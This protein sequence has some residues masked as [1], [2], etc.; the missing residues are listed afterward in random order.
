MGLNLP[1]AVLPAGTAN[2]FATLLG[3]PTDIEEAC[4]AILAG[5]IH[6]MDLGRA[7]GRYFANVF[8]CGLFTDVSQK[9]PTAWK[10]NLGKIAYYI[11]GIGDLPRFRK[12]E[13]LHH[14]RRRRLPRQ[15]HHLLRL[16]R[17]HGRH[18]AARLSLRGGRR[19]ARHFG[20]QRRYAA[21]HPAHGHPV[22]AP[23]ASPPALP[24]RHRSHPVQPTSRGVRQRRTYGCGR[25]A[26]PIVPHRHHMR[27]RCAAGHP[28]RPKTL[29]VERYGSPPRRPDRERC[30]NTILTPFFVKTKK[31]ITFASAY[32]LKDTLYGGCSSVG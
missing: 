30:R 1:V 8:S 17:T 13:A 26:R 9:T 20:T 16:Q 23:A 22:P 31:Y 24:G 21:R 12:M 11:N 5:R 18:A 27:A 6:A 25:P 4:R 2:D 15:C 28:S 32:P 19:P 3:M 14:L 7:N 29:R 10:N